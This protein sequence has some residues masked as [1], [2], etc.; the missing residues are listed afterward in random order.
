MQV[1]RE[2]RNKSPSCPSSAAVI[3]ESA[4]AVKPRQLNATPLLTAADHP[5]NRSRGVQRT[6]ARPLNFAYSE[7]T[8]TS[9]KR[10]ASPSC[11]SPPGGSGRCSR[12]ENT[13]PRLPVG[14]SRGTPKAEVVQAVDNSSKRVL[15]STRTAK[16]K[17]EAGKR[18][19]LSTSCSAN[20]DCIDRAKM[21]DNTMGCVQRSQVNMV[22]PWME[23]DV[24]IHVPRPNPPTVCVPSSR[25]VTPLPTFVD[26]STVPLPQH[27]SDR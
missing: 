1:F 22:F 24:K 25:A 15:P 2:T 18:R 20:T 9:T 27:A 3:D 21:P 6:P 10:G 11:A 4:A 26:D 17:L 7:T 13:S 16:I 14:E 19:R 23:E 8:P 12:G 5:D